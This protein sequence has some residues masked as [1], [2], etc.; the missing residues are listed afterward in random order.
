MNT[1]ENSEENPLVPV[2]RFEI[3]QAARGHNRFGQK[4][5]NLYVLF[6]G[7]ELAIDMELALGAHFANKTYNGRPRMELAKEKAPT[8]V[9]LCFMPSGRVKIHSDYLAAW[10]A[11]V[12]NEIFSNR[13]P[14]SKKKQ[15]PTPVR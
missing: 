3:S 2:I 14:R 7:K 15:K 12:E 13:K 10:I 1:Q 9:R 5:I 11:R 6:K 8:E 4:A